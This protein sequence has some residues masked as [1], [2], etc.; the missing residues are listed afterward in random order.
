MKYNLIAFWVRR[1]LVETIIVERNL[2][3]NTQKSYR[4]TLALLL[5]FIAKREGKSPDQLTVETL[6]PDSI[7][8]FFQDL[9]N[10]RG[11]SMATCNQRLTAIHGLAQFIA[12]KSPEHVLWAGQVRAIPFKK[13]G[14]TVVGYLEKSEIDAILEAPDAMTPHGHRDRALLLFMYNTGARVSE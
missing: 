8:E 5:P 13:T 11:C 14:K 12:W 1:F 3:K 6:S 7:R 2:S 4:D 10:G 9:Q